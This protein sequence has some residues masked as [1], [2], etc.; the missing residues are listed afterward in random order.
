MSSQ[1]EVSLSAAGEESSS[2]YFTI[3]ATNDSYLSQLSLAVKNAQSEVNKSLTKIVEEE[4]AVPQCKRPK[5][6][7]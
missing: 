4:K 2:S 1:I 6:G 7:H 3:E 5:N